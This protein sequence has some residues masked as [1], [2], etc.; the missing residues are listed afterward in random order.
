MGNFEKILMPK[1]YPRPVKAESLGLG[2]RHQYF[3]WL[4]GEF[5]H[6]LKGGFPG[7]GTALARGSDSSHCGTGLKITVWKKL[8]SN[9]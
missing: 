3:L 6:C 4:P 1:L 8:R 7:V 5:S 2:P 9:H